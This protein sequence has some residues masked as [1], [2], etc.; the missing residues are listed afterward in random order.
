MDK[1]V[2]RL[3]GKW[4][5]T[6]PLAVIFLWALPPFFRGIQSIGSFVPL[7]FSAGTL[8][9]LWN[10]PL[11]EKIRG[12]R[13]S[14]N[15]WRIALV[16]YFAGIAC[17]GVLLCMLLGAGT[18]RP[19]EEDRTVVVLGCQVRGETPSLMLEK[20][21]Q[22]A[23]AYL[24]AHPDAPCVVSGGQGP[25]E[26]ISEAEAMYRWLVE[27][28]IEPGR[29]YLES[30]STSTAENLRYSAAVIREEGLPTDVAVA[31]DGFHQW[32]GAYYAAENGLSAAALPAKTPW[33][34][35]ECYYVR[36]VL[37]AAKTLLLG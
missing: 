22:A 20:R 33:Y 9:F 25:G 3:F 13:W 32:R 21:L 15:L 24:E 18:N 5:A 16:L 7:I 19:G 14:R 36:E 30:A 11:R 37:A 4:L 2:L 26:A 10:R 12:R 1:P 29:I 23:Y 17:F 6:L 27:R 35:L 28:G 34:L 31:T 8:L